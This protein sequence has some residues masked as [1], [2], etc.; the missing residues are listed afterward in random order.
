MSLPPSKK[1]RICNLYSNNNN[2]SIPTNI[3]E[4]DIYNFEEDFPT[5][6]NMN[7]SIHKSIQ[8]N[9]D[10]I[11]FRNSHN[12]GRGTFSKVYKLINKENP[13]D[14]TDALAIKIFKSSSPYK[15]SAIEEINALNILKGCPFIV[16]IV[17]YFKITTNHIAIVTPFY[18]Y[19]L[20]SYMSTYLN[21]TKITYGN[22]MSVFVSLLNACCCMIKYGISSTDMKPENIFLNVRMNGNIEKVVLGDFSM[23][24]YLN[25]HQETS[26]NK[27]ICTKYYRPPEIIFQL[28]K[29]QLKNMDLW[30][31][32]CVLYELYHNSVLFHCSA[33][34]SDLE[35]SNEN[36]FHMQV[37]VLGIPSYEYFEKYN[38]DYSDKYIYINSDEYQKFKEPQQEIIK[39]F[40]EI[41]FG[42]ELILK[43]L[44][45]DSD[46]RPDPE[47]SLTYIK[48]RLL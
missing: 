7:M 23:P 26:Y 15:K 22:F 19:N 16:D 43:Y 38:I 27:W 11:P 10:G 14:N 47:F 45:W 28:P 2:N 17:G 40:S 31:L 4:K 42:S 37:S 18:D 33:N 48:E 8:L 12:I 1:R 13:R 5:D 20:L 39:Q 25:T 41:P 3:T 36:L 9:I 46:E 34:D 6:I 24:L 44:N 21:T 35:K 30:S 29:P 32:G